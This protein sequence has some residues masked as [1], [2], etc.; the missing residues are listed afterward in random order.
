MST[1][2][3]V[4]SSKATLT[5]GSQTG[6]VSAS[7]RGGMRRRRAK[8]TSEKKIADDEFMAAAIGDVEW[9]KQSLRENGSQINYDKNVRA[10]Q[11]FNTIIVCVCV[12]A[13]ACM[14]ACGRARGGASLCLSL[15][16]Y[17][18]TNLS[19]FLFLQCEGEI[20]L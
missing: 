7:G 9:L 5:L 14:R 6:S 19:M 1:S 17:V 4:P 8:V 11:T 18:T 15:C 16:V 3:G 20:Y 13:R 2:G 12:R 10:L